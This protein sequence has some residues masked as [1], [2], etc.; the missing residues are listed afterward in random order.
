MFYVREQECRGDVSYTRAAGADA[1]GSAD[2]SADDD[3]ID[4]DFRE[5]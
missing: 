1:A 4:G 2:S 5:V 3:I